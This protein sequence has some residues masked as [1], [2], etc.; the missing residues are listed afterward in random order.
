MYIMCIGCLCSPDMFR[1]DRAVA[2]VRPGVTGLGLASSWWACCHGAPL[3]VL[4]HLLLLEFMY[5]CNALGVAP[6]AAAQLP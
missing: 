6:V 4:F 2:S 1:R 5:V 3:V